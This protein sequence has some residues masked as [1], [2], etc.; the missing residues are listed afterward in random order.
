[1]ALG[2]WNLFDKHAESYYGCTDPDALNATAIEIYPF[3]SRES[4]AAHIGFAKS[5]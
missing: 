3:G 2:V 4:Q 5:S 1:M